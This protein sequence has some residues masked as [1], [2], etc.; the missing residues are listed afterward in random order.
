MLNTSSVSYLIWSSSQSYRVELLLFP[1]SDDEI[2]ALAQG[3]ES[4]QCQRGISPRWWTLESKFNASF[5]LIF[6]SNGPWGLSTNSSAWKHCEISLLQS[7]RYCLSWEHQGQLLCTEAWSTFG[8][9][10]NAESMEGKI[11]NI[12]LYSYFCNKYFVWLWVKSLS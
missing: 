7:L 1:F 10:I 9:W 3:D 4:G 8:R 11:A 5:S 6:S 2:E 12:A